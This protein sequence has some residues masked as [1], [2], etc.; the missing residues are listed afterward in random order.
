M[1]LHAEKLVVEAFH[2]GA[3]YFCGMMQKSNQVANYPSDGNA[4]TG[5]CN[6]QIGICY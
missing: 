3:L 5:H 4:P 6:R 2:K 1:T